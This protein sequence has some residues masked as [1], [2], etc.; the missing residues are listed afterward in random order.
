MRSSSLSPRSDQASVPLNN[1]WRVR[2]DGIQW[3]L[4]KSIRQAKAGKWSGWQATKFHL[5]RDVLLRSIR[6]A[7]IIVS[8]AAMARLSSLPERHQL[9]IQTRGDQ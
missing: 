2:D 8:E 6:D 3:V 9:S 7:G 1:K 4:E 5:M